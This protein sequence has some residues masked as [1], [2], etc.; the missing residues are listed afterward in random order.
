MVSVSGSPPSDETAINPEFSV[1]ANTIV[2]SS[3]HVPPN[4]DGAEASI[5][6]WPPATDTT[7]S[8]PCAKNPS[9]RPSGEKNGE[10]ASSEPGIARASKSDS[11]RTH[12]RG[13]SSPF[14]DTYAIVLPSLLIAGGPV[15][16]SSGSSAID[17]RTGSGRASGRSQPHVASANA[18]A[19][20][21]TRAGTHARR[22][23]GGG[24]SPVCVAGSPDASRS[25][26]RTSAM[27]RRRC[28]GFLA[29]HRRSKRCTAGGVSAGSAS[30][31]GSSRITAAIVSVTVSPGN[32]RRPVSIS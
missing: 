15:T 10:R 4:G 29:R 24:A 1:A 17:N 3:A 22:G 11:S 5:R 19:A 32:A 7:R 21:A 9:D 20:T 18:M 30:Q 28:V 14:W 6:G 26:R 23:P 27:S 2:P 8:S 31:S 25:S 16:S 12:S 13:A